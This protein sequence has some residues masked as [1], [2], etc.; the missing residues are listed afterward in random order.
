M[1][2]EALAEQGGRRRGAMHY[3]Y[4]VQSLAD[5]S[6]RYVG[7]TGD[8]KTRLNEHNGGGSGHTSRHRPWRLVTYVAFSD[9]MQAEAFERYLKSGSGHA[10]ARRRLWLS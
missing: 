3:V 1:P 7:M 10:F 5:P 4:L 2:C 8:L 9:R 6:R